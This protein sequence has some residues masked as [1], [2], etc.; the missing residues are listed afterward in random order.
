MDNFNLERFL[1]GQ[2]F[3]FECAL[4]EIRNGRKEG[5]W[6]WY[7]FPQI[8]GLG[9][10]P[11][12]QYYGISGKEE[13]QAYLEHPILGTRLKKITESLLSIEG[14][15]IEEILPPVDVMKVRSCMTLF[16]FVCPNACFDNVLVKYY[17]GQRDQMTISSLQRDR[18][19]ITGLFDPE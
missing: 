19:E 13:A 16:D 15:K 10:S 11:N 4:K 17:D 18:A 5:H 7:V 3:S 1:E 8:K 12:S 9:H 6:I 14:K 2:R